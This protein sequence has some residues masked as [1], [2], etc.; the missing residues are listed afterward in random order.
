M[1]LL[2]SLGRGCCEPTI[3]LGVLVV[4]RIL[5]RVPGARAVFCATGRCHDRM[6]VVH[7]FDHNHY[8]SR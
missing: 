1:R 5:G 8:R 3:A 2:A 6:L 4:E 7:T